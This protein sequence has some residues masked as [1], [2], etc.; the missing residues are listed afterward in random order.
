MLDFAL[1]PPEINS[2]LMYSGPGPGPMLT[3]AAA[4]AGLSAELH[5]MASA[6]H[7]VIAALTD[8]SWS[9]PA[10]ASMAGA[11]A[12]Q[13]EWLVNAAGQADQVASQAVAAVSRRGRSAW[14]RMS[15]RH[16]EVRGTSAVGMAHRS[17]RSRW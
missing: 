15:P 10:S 13:V 11:S 4:W 7:G 3:A 17:S 2:A 16:I 1:L 12:A 8:G 9:G 6:Y 14:S 5:T